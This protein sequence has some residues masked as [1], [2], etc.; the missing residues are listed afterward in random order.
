M[1]SYTKSCHCK[2][3]FLASSSSQ[4]ST[5]HTPHICINCINCIKTPLPPQ[6]IEG[7]EAARRDIIVLLFY[8]LTTFDRQCNPFLKE[9]LER[10][11]FR[12]YPI[13]CLFPNWATFCASITAM[14]GSC[15]S[16]ASHFCLRNQPHHSG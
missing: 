13:Q 11:G 1:Y 9:S 6:S 5:G 7:I 4:V 3:L 12:G 15:A 8:S 2:S 10:R 16:V 14:T